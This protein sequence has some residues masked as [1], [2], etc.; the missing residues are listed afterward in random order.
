M[1]MKCLTDP[2]AFDEA[3]MIH[4][5]A[6]EEQHQLGGLTHRLLLDGQWQ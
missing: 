3:L 2:R 4:Q 5:Q 6:K 1:I